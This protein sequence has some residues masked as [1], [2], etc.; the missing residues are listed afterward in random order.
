MADYFAHRPPLP[1][2]ESVLPQTIDPS[3][4]SPNNALSVWNPTYNSPSPNTLLASLFGPQSIDPYPT[5]SIFDMD[6]SLVQPYDPS[7]DFTH[8]DGLSKTGTGNGPF[9]APNMDDHQFFKIMSVADTRHD[10]PIGIGVDPFTMDNAASSESTPI[11]LNGNTAYNSNF[12]SYVQ[13][14]YRNRPEHPAYLYQL[15]MLENPDLLAPYFPSLEQRHQVCLRPHLPPY[16]VKTS[17]Q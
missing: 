6:T 7:Y 16:S 1:A 17:R 8:I 13:P 3:N 14:E 15:Q 2:A 12:A 5:A 9:M 10:S 11:S 4:S